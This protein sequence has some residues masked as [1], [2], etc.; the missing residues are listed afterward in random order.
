M[1]NCA[2]CKKKIGWGSSYSDDGRD[3]CSNCFSKH[4]KGEKLEMR[5]EEEKEKREEKRIP[6]YI[7]ITLVVVMLVSIQTFHLRGMALMIVSA[8]G[9]LIGIRLMWS[10]ILKKKK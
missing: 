6:D 4:L 8:L 7:W 1:A 9:V 10:A 3:Y 5:K 2:I